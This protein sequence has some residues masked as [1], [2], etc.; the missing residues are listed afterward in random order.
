MNN[1]NANYRKYN[2]R[3]GNSSTYHKKDGT[4]IR[5]K[6]NRESNKEIDDEL[7]PNMN[8]VSWNEALKALEDGKNVKRT[9]WWYAE[10]AYISLSMFNHEYQFYMKGKYNTGP[11]TVEGY[12]LVYADIK[13]TKWIIL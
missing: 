1:K 3:T 10:H 11:D 4:S 8:T 2:D 13:S 6:L 9:D 7:D 5:L 12:G